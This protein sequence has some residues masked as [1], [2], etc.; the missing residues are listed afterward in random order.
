[1][2]DP[3]RLVNSARRLYGDDF[4]RL[5]GEVVPVPEAQR[6]RAEGRRDASRA[7]RSPT[8]P[9]TPPTTSP[10][11]TRTPAGPSS[12]TSPACASSRA[13]SS[14]RRPRRPTST[15]RR[16][17]RSID[18]ARGLGADCARAHPLRQGRP[19][20]R[21]PPRDAA[22]PALRAGAHG[23]ARCPARTS[24]R[25]S[26]AQIAQAAGEELTP[27][28]LQASPPDQIFQGLDRYWRKR[29]EREAA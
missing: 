23:R 9:G 21:G 5:W 22:R 12:A 6:P 24:W 10:T 15:S 11:S 4:D 16:G 8:R 25:R 14:S 17:T 2:I 1:M 26:S 7:S 28:F 29:A 20:R 3:E 19:R 27:A 18:I 13:A